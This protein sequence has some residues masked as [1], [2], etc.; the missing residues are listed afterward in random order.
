MLYLIEL[1]EKVEGELRGK[2]R[3]KVPAGSR[4]VL[5]LPGGGGFGKPS[6]RPREQV[7]ADVAAG[8]VS[9]EQAKDDYG[10]TD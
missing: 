5:Q 3:Q 4:L 9:P 8:Y 6:D 2:G 7:E 10:R 1:A